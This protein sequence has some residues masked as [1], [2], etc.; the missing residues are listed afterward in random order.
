VL[1]PWAAWGEAAMLPLG[2]FRIVQNS[3][4]LTR[5]L[6]T[7]GVAGADARVTPPHRIDDAPLVSR[8]F[9]YG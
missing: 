1:V 2:A 8:A 9:R 5:S 7:P 6:G 4:G 3:P